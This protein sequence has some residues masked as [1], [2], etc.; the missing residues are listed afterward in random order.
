MFKIND[1]SYDLRNPN[2]LASKHKS[3]KKCGIDTTDFKGPQ[4]WQ[5]N[6]LE[7]RYSQSL[8]LFKSNLKQIQGLP[9]R[10]KICCS[11]IANLGYID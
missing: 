5:N 7:I 4:I 11:F 8:S 1:C 9:C 10:C 2:I 6:P 3:F